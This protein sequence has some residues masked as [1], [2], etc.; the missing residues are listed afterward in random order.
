[1]KKSHEGGQRKTSTRT[2]E[3]RVGIFWVVDGKPLIDSTSLNE[4]E[5]YGDHLTHQSCLRSVW[6]GG[7]YSP[8]RTGKGATRPPKAKGYSRYCGQEP[9]P[10]AAPEG[11]KPRPPTRALVPDQ[12]IMPF[13]AS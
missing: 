10:S 13:S 5:P 9:L 12:T 8:S 4:A 6:F 11:L 1:M 3:P 2:T 7:D